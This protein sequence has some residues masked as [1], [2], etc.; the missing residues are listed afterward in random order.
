[1]CPLAAGKVLTDAVAKMLLKQ[2]K[3][4]SG[5]C[6]KDL[7]SSDAVKDFRWKIIDQGQTEVWYK[8]KIWKFLSSGMSRTNR[9]ALSTWLFKKVLILFLELISVQE[10]DLNIIFTGNGK[11]PLV[12]ITQG[13]SVWL[14]EEYPSWSCLKVL[15]YQLSIVNLYVRN[16]IMEV[17]FKFE[18]VLNGDT[19]S[20][21]LY[22]I[23][24]VIHS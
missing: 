13:V 24:S 3:A 17:S 11:P 4:L 7:K 12:H 10:S 1:M 14:R 2:R 9:G 16:R 6:W 20:K 5:R 15:F 8:W 18:F 23:G 19:K 22:T 21:G